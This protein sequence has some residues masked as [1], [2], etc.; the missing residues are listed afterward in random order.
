M[1]PLIGLKNLTDLSF[2]TAGYTGLDVIEKLPSLKT[3][4][5][6]GRVAQSGQTGLSW[7]LL[8]SPTVETIKLSQLGA[9]HIR[10]ISWPKFSILK[11][12]TIT[13]PLGK[14]PSSILNEEGLSNLQT[15][16]MQE[17][18]CDQGV[19][20]KTTLPN[21]TS[22]TLRSTQAAPETDLVCIQWDRLPNLTEL[23]VQGYRVDIPAFLARLPAALA[24]KARIQNP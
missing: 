19:W 12:L 3:I 23:V 16:N 11:S 21:L 1:R 5:I 20:P 7:A 15:F 10:Q 6:V 4:S 13:S 8:G 17:F 9:N 24:Q 22:I 18:A 14:L 2:L